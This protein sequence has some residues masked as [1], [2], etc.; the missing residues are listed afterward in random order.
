MV[1]KADAETIFLSLNE[2]HLSATAA[3][4]CPLWGA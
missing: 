3:F 4:L 1:Q 2:N